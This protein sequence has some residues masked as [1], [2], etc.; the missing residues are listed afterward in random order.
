MT[1][2]VRVGII[3]CDRYKTCDGGKCFRAVRNKE[4]AFKT[5]GAPVQV[6]GFSSCGGCPGGNIENVVAGMKKYGADVIHFGTG[7]LAGYPPCPYIEIF[8]TYIFAQS[9]AAVVGTHPMPT[10]Y[11]NTHKL[12]EDWL[13][14]HLDYLDRCGIMDPSEVDLYD[15]TKEEYDE[16]LRLDLLK[17]NNQ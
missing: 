4:G 12:I 8:R 17:E 14:L 3:I 2:T 6:V 9:M 7:F 10:N 11:I 15:S 13:P 16:E 1:G 5:Y